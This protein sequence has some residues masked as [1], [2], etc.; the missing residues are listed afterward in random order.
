MD[1]TIQEFFHEFRQSFL[2]GAEANLSF[3]LS[4]FMETVSGELIDT[5][6]IDG[7]EFLPLSCT[8]RNES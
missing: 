6:F 4:E 8:E 5:G 7:F 1:Q 3:Q 2:A